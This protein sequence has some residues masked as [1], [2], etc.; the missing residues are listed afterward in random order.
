MK[1]SDIF[2]LAVSTLRDY[3]LLEK[4]WRVEWDNGKRRAGSCNYARRVITLSRIIL[5]GAPDE[6]VR[7]TILHE[8]AHALT[9]GHSHD[10]VWRA[11][12][13]EMGGTGKRTHDMETPKGR[14]E[15][16]C[17]NCGVVGTRHQAQGAMRRGINRPERSVYTHRSCGGSIWL[18]DTQDPRV[19]MPDGERVFLPSMTPTAV[20]VPVA[21]AKPS[22]T[23]PV[24][25]W[26]P[27]C[28]CGCGASTKGGRYLPGHDARHVSEVFDRWLQSEINVRGAQALLPT[29]AL[30]AK[31]AKRI[32]AYA[33]KHN[34][35]R[36][37]FFE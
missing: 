8:V 2:D 4:F 18:R 33:A 20:R 11:K 3:G 22:E 1:S 27:I 14:Y 25:S 26:S 15:M 17:T 21:A 30:Q 32:E 37:I 19:S 23:P 13:I 5:P 36:D 35:N 16:V 12:L 7:E 9:P 24:A 34:D 31:L 6:E 28:T 10:A 29:P